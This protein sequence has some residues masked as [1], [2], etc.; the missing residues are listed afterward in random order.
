MSPIRELEGITNSYKIKHPKF[1]RNITPFS[2][3]SEMNE[4][5]SQI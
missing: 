4:N 1:L 2:K 3:N 5:D